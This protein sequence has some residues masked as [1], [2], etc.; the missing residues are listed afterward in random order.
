MDAKPA[1]FDSPSLGWTAY[2]VV[3]ALFPFMALPGPCEVG[4][5]RPLSGGKRARWPAART[6]PGPDAKLRLPWPSGRVTRFHAVACSRLVRSVLPGWA[7]AGLTGSGLCG[8]GGVRGSP[9]R[10][11]LRRVRSSLPRPKGKGPHARAVL[12]CVPRT[13]GQMSICLRRREF[14]AALGG[15][16]AAAWPSSCG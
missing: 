11:S 16:A 6:L 3:P 15:A 9:P 7:C 1:P 5:V 4:V 2:H 12:V 14:I 10:P 13:E 8:A